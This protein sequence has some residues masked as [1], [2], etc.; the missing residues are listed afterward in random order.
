MRTTAI[1]PA[2]GFGTRLGS[3]V[4]K[5]FIELAGI[6][7]IVRTLRVFEQCGDID[8]VVV[9]AAPEFHTYILDLKTRYSLQKL[10]AL[11]QG[12]SERQHSVA[13][14]LHSPAC[15]DAEI[16]VIHDAVRPFITPSLVHRIV[17]AA[18]VHGAAIPGVIPK[19]TIKECT[20]LP[21]LPSIAYVHTT[22]ERS[23]LRVIQTP[24]AFRRD[25]LTRAFA[26]AHS[27]GIIGT[28]DASLVEASG[29]SVVVIPGEEENIKITTALD[30]RWAEYII[31][32]T[33][34]HA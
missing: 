3:T 9:A 13:N 12:G 1:I 7:I 17:Q 6:P 18:I 10:T 22:Y 21:D 14:A 11:V 32:S 29:V 34:S 15:S 19:D 20:Y 28:D 23:H 33:S 2:A 30:I 16:V 8:T 25:L 24:Q 26:H 27:H 4:P 31:T 5:Q